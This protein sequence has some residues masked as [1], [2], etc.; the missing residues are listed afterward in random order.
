VLGKAACDS[1]RGANSLGGTK[2]GGIQAI[3]VHIV[4]VDVVAIRSAPRE[5]AKGRLA[6][7]DVKLSGQGQE[8]EEEEQG[9]QQEEGEMASADGARAAGVEG[10]QHGAWS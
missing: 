3:R 5:V 10:G 2:A 1:R 6:Q 8:E 7:S 9:Y 4:K